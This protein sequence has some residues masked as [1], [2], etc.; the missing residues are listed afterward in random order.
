MQWLQIANQSN[1]DDLN[2]VRRE[3]SRCFKKKKRK[4]LKGRTNE[5]EAKSNNKIIRD[6][7]SVV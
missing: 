1:K 2:N 6:R 7:K 4:Y 3:A 5:F